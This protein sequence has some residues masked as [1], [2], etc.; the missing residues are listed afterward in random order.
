MLTREKDGGFRI[1][2]DLWQASEGEVGAPVFVASFAMRADMS[3]MSRIEAGFG[4]TN[5]EPKD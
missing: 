2:A 3:L 1:A 4:R 5:P